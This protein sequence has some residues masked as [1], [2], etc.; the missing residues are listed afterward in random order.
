[1]SVVKARPKG[2]LG[3]AKL[4]QFS[5]SVRKK[6]IKHPRVEVVANG[7]LEL[8]I[9]QGFLTEQECIDLMTEVDRTSRPSTLYQGTEIEGYRTS[10]SGDLDP[11]H[12]LVQIIEGRICNLMGVSPRHGETLQG[13]RYAV[14]QVFKTHHDFFH[15][16]ETYWEMERGRGGQRSWTAMIYLNEPGGGGE[17]NFPKAGLCV[18]PRSAML[19]LWNNMDE[20]GAPNDLTLHEGCAVTEGTKYIVT[21]WFREHFWK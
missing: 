5:K 3:S 15:T 9:V 8:Y 19:V 16:T 14:G 12:P 10:Y 2:A 1:V 4:A 18:S 11:F 21:K 6:L 7:G 20:L 17:T 13:Q